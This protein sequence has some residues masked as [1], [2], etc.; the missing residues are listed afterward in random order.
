MSLFDP[1]VDAYQRSPFYLMLRRQKQR[2]EFRRWDREGR[3]SPPPHLVKQK[4]IRHYAREHGCE[5]LVETGTFRGDMLLAMQ[6][7]FRRMYSI[8]LHPELHR[9]AVRL[10]HGRQDVHLLQGDSGQRINDVLGKLNQ[11]ALFWLDGHYS[12]GR[13]A[14]SDLNT[15]IVAELDA[16]LAHPVQ[17]HVILIDDARVFNGTNDYP[18]VD[19]I[20]ERLQ[21][22]GA[23]DVKVESDAIVITR[24]AA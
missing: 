9:R 7:T 12:G 6:R 17:N 14:K 4:L 15:P 20:R 13:T 11:P 19:A 21:V 22:V 24:K 23:F 3:L 5:T 16:I 8:E 1:L 2:A 18:T 10:F